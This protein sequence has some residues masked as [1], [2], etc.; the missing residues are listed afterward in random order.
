M[1]HTIPLATTSTA[2]GATV[3]ASAGT[4]A[5]GRTANIAMWV[6]QVIPILSGPAGLALAALLTGAIVTQLAVFAPITALTPAAYLIPVAIIAWGRRYQTVRLI[7]L[8]RRVTA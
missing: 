1:T 2:T 6:L 5:P 3:T 4:V 7:R 8:V